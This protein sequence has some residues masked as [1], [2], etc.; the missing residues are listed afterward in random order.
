MPTTRRS[1][2]P[3]AR[4]RAGLAG[5]L[6]LNVALLLVLAAVSFSPPAEAQQRARAH[7]TAV[8]GMVNGADS[9]V[10]YIADVTNQKLLALTFDPSTNA[11][12]GIASADLAADAT[13]VARRR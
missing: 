1:D 5:L 9:G 8:A 2:P 13:R 6:V 4:R 10:V 11:L 12:R 7:Y 3:V